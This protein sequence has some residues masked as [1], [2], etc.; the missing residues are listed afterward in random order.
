MLWIYKMVPTFV[1][2]A[3]AA[4]AHDM[5]A[6]TT[7]KAVVD[8]RLRGHDDRWDRLLEIL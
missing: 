6:P 1:T 4:I 8:G 5:S 3:E 7:L 2:A